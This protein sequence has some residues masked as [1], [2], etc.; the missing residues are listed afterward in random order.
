[1]AISK[2][3]KVKFL[4]NTDWLFEGIVDAEEKEYRLLSYFQKLNKNL[5]EMKVYPMFTEISLHLGNIQTL[6]NQNKILYSERNLSSFDDELLLSDL[7]LKDIPVL[8]EDEYE[9]YQKILNYTL[10]KLE[11]YFGITKSIWVIVYDS[12]KLNVKKNK[13]N[14][15]S[16]SGFF[17]FTTKETNY[18]WR[19]NIRK[20]KKE[21]N[22]TKTTIKL[23]HKEPISDLTIQEIISNF[24]LL[25]NKPKNHKLPIFEVI[26]EDIFPLEET[27]IPIFKRKV[28]SYISQTVKKEENTVKKLIT[29][30]V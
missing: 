25:Q 23:I 17:Y 19:Y 6:I 11:Y 26:C 16:K 24:M 7:K 12:I 28:M 30:G 10:P 18:I 13:N 4:M 3:N 27:L 8:A 5:D 22:T 1:M 14:L 15:Q 20:V 21:E 9:E 2:K 29:N